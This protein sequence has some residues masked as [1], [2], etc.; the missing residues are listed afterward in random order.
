MRIRRLWSKL[1]LRDELVK[2]MGEH[3]GSPHFNRELFNKQVDSC[4]TIADVKKAAVAL[5]NQI[6]L[7]EEQEKSSF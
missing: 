3:L 7:A 1:E 2:E 4:F 5:R 6:V